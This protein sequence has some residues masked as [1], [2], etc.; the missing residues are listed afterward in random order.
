MGGQFVFQLR[1]LSR[2]WGLIF[3]PTPNI[4]AD[5]M[6]K[7]NTWLI[8]LKYIAIMIFSVKYTIVKFNQYGH[9]LADGGGVV[10]VGLG[11]ASIV[12]H[13]PNPPLKQNKTEELFLLSSSYGCQLAIDSSCTRVVTSLRPYS[14]GDL[15]KLLSLFVFLHELLCNSTILSFSDGL[16]K[17]KYGAFSY[18]N[19]MC[20]CFLS[21]CIKFT[22]NF[23][24][25]PIYTMLGYTQSC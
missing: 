8:Q 12:P 18:A 7:C 20:T 22:F 25:G 5:M 24:E 4:P 19:I 15:A 10:V 21:I 23:L 9:D 11:S 3:L 17:F 13:R 1:R 2:G 14:C 16:G 6:L